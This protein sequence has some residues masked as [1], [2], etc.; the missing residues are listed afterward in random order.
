MPD[1]PVPLAIVVAIVGGVLVA[2]IVNVFLVMELLSDELWTRTAGDAVAALLGGV[3]AAVVI[4]QP[5]WRAG[6]GAVAAAIGV[7]V[8]FTGRYAADAL[9]ASG[10]EI[11]LALEVPLS[12]VVA[13]ACGAASSAAVGRV[14]WRA[15]AT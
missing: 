4:T 8:V 14:R 5:R 13:F 3:P 15:R 11:S 2:Y 1:R 12:A 9:S 6:L 7:A 10:G